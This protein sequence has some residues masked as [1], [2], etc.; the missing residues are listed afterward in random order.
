MAGFRCAGGR[1]T[2]ERRG[3]F[4]TKLHLIVYTVDSTSRHDN[5]TAMSDDK[6]AGLAKEE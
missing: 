4:V 2:L 3:F 5:G 6:R 1:P